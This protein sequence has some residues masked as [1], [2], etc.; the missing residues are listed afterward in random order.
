MLSRMLLTV[1]IGFSSV[2]HAS[3]EVQVWSRGYI[4]SCG[5]YSG[6]FEDFDITFRD[7]ALPWG[8]TVTA[9]IGFAGYDALGGGSTR[10]FD[11]DRN[12]EVRMEGTSPFT[13]TGSVSDQLHSR[14]S[15]RFLTSMK[16][17]FRVHTPGAPAYYVNGGSSWG[18][19]AVSTAVHGSP[20]V[21][22]STGLPEKK[23]KEVRIIKKD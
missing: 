1:I 21:D 13:W 8:T 14:T 11:W 9:V 7:S 6:T 17:V 23:Q 22:S 3:P 19:F 15:A 5:Y 10:P 4:S 16:F 12:R 2:L 18:S 20:C